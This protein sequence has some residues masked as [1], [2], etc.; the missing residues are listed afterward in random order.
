MSPVE[1]SHSDLLV[2]V[3]TREGAAGALW[4]PWERRGDFAKMWRELDVRRASWKRV[5]K[6]TLASY[7][8]VVDAFFDRSWLRFDCVLGEGATAEKVLA[9]GPPAKSAHK[10]RADVTKKTPARRLAMMFLRIAMAAR[11]EK[12]SVA[13]GRIIQRVEE[14][15]GVEK[16]ATDAWS[17]ARRFRIET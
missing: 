12:G 9:L 8:A 13:Q 6:K 3:V 1:V 5:K 4:M 10:V 15:L 14:R 11:A 17:G 2:H 16:L 7:E